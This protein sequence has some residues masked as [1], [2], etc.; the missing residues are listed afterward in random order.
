PDEAAL[1]NPCRAAATVTMTLDAYAE[2][3][4]VVADLPTQVR[5]HFLAKAQGA[6]V[7][8]LA[9]HFCGRDAE[10]TSLSAWLRDAEGGL[11]VV[12]GEAGSGKSALLGHLVVLGN[13]ELVD[14]L[15]RAAVMPPPPPAAR[16]PAGAFDA[17]V[18]LTG[19]TLI[20]AVREVA[21]ATK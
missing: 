9:W 2:L 12:T 8:E 17:I 21:E 11:R 10:L 4:H 19:K 6:E 1:E 15:S 3:R 7:G 13:E 20:E 16:P 18:H 5:S 14:A